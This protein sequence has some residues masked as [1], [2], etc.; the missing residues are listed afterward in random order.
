MSVRVLGRFLGGKKVELKHEPS[1]AVMV[2]DAPKD[3]QGEGTSFSPTDLVA[4][5]LGSCMMT[6]MA[7]LAER[8][9]F[10]LTGAHFFVDKSMNAAPR[11]IAA[12]PI[13][14]HLPKVLSSEQKLKLE[15]A[16]DLCPVKQSLLPDIAVTVQYYYDVG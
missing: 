14:F 7:I 9:G 15:R 2:T 8:G 12:L 3:N 4:S 10:D 5:A 1:G 13:V 11:R 16:A 6:I